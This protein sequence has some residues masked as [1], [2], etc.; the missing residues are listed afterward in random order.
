MSTQNRLAERF[1]E[2][3]RVD[4]ETK[5]EGKFQ[6][7]LQKKCETL[8]LRAYEDDTKEQTGLGGGNLICELAATD[9][10]SPPL[11][12]CCHSD[13]VGPGKNIQPQVKDGNVCSDG[14]T[15]LAADDKAGIAICLEMVA[16]LRESGA[17]HGKLEFV[18]TV[19]EEI[20]LVGAKA[21]DMSKLESKQCYVLDFSGPVGGIIVASPTMYTIQAVFHGKPAHAGLEPE[22]GISAIE[23]AVRSLAK[24]KWGR[25][26]SETTANIGV[27][28]GGT[29][30]NIVAEKA[31]VSAEVRSISHEHCGEVLHAILAAMDAAAQ[32][33]GG[34]VEHEYQMLTHGFRLDESYATVQMAARALESIG[35][36]PRYEVSGGASDANAFGPAGIET[37]NLSIGYEKVHTVDEF[38][39]I[40][41]MEKATEVA[42]Y[43]A[44][45]RS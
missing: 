14:S 17:K 4:S 34:T 21:L 7:F 33:M 35:I 39:P 26:D 36:S 22:K 24:L 9:E 5:D 40:A 6:A 29:A 28:Q 32:E 41:E 45:H 27:I 38:I 31:T 25:L 43:L 23:M 12:F 1:M 19:G 8:G 42:Y 37:T 13:T 30:N 18:F 3:V 20:G 2:L 44:T 16:R 15:I 11:L 10:S